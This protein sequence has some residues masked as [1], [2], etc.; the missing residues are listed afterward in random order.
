MITVVTDIHH[1]FGLPE[2]KGEIDMAQLLIN[3][4]INCPLAMRSEIVQQTK[5][6]Q[7]AGVTTSSSSPW[8]CPVI[9]VRMKDY[10]EL[11]EVT[12]VC[13]FQELIKFWMV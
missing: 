7:E 3:T 5:M 1:A 13:P 4:G 10:R 12:K 6:M 11:D 2:E 8:S 9:L